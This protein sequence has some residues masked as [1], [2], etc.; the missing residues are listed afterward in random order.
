M[1]T[2][3]VLR[4]GAAVCALSAALALT[5]CSSLNASTSPDQAILA[6]CAVDKQVAADVEIDG[7]GSSSGDAIATERL[8][9]TADVVRRTAICSGYLLV[10][11]FSASSG[12]TVTIYDGDLSLPGATDN[13]RLRRVDALVEK[14]MAEITAKYGDAIAALPDGGSDITSVYRLA[15]EYAAQLGDGYQLH[16]YVLTD[17]LNN[18]GTDLTSQVLTPEQATDLASTVNVPALPGSSITAAGLGRINGD[19]APSALVEGL[20]A[21]YNALC[22]KAGAKTC[23]SVTDYTA[24][25]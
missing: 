23:V 4:T 5:A 8:A 12:A 24:G 10:R 14:V 6:A 9:I 25:R 16:L 13:A 17:G 2:F 19:P 18:I 15:G 21:F 22:S 3:T 11:A 20:V 7:S 1:T